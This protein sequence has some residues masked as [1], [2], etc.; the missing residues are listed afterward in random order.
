MSGTVFEIYIGAEP[1]GPLRS[2]REITLETGRGIVGDRYY[3]GSG[4]FSERFMGTHDNEVTLIEA[5]VIDRFNASNGRS[6]GYGECRRNIV[7]RDIRLNDL[8]DQTFRIGQVTLQGIRL[9][10][11]CQH[12][13]ELTTPQILSDM[14]HRAGL[15]AQIITDGRIVVEDSIAVEDAE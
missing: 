7:T 15:R 12:L 8:V 11:P 9:C 6:L 3:A 1:C 4:T 10:E 13:A 5:E 14:V 2:V